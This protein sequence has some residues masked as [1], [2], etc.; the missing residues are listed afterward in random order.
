MSNGKWKA[1]R[2]DGYTGTIW[3]CHLNLASVANV[4]FCI[5]VIQQ[6]EQ[7][8]H[9]RTCIWELH[10]SVRRGTLQPRRLRQ[11]LRTGCTNKHGVLLA[12][13]P[14]PETRP[15]PEPAEPR[16]P[17]GHMTTRC[18]SLSAARGPGSLRDVRASHADSL[19]LSSSHLF[20]VTAVSHSFA[21]LWTE[22]SSW[23]GIWTGVHHSDKSKVIIILAITTVWST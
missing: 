7:H 18:V 1:F 14:H 5:S 12:H 17:Q 10:Q 6:R 8:Q 16:P 19:Q 11:L 13:Q 20:P 4:D 22:T 3:W 21:L 23:S 9:S 2:M 15:L